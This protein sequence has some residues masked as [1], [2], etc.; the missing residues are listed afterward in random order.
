MKDELL[1]ALDFIDPSSLEYNDWLAVGIILKN[2][3]HSWT[4]WDSW[5]QKD[6]KRYKDGECENKWNGFNGSDKSLTKA[7][8]FKMAIEQ[9]YKPKR[10]DSKILNFDS[11]INEIHVEKKTPVEQL[12]TF[13]NI[14]FKDDDYVGYVTHEVK[15]DSKL[16]KYYPL[17]GI[18]T[19][20]KKELIDSLDYY[21]EDIHNTVGDTKYE[22]GGW[23]RINPLDGKGVKDS[24]VTRFDYCLVESDELSIDDQKDLYVRLQLPIA[25]LTLS[26]GKSV[27]AVIKIG[28]KNIEEYK[29]RVAYLYKYLDDNGLKVDKQNSNPSR[30]TRMPGLMRKENEQTLI[31]TNVGKPNWDEWY[32]LANNDFDSIIPLENPNLP[33]FPIEAFPG[34]VSAYCYEVAETTQTPVDMACVSALA[35]LALAMQRRYLV[36][37]KDDWKEQTSLYLMVVAEPSDRKSAVL[38][39]FNK[40]ISAFEIQYNK[41][42]EID[43]E[44][45]RIELKE[46]KEERNNVI[47][48]HKNKEATDDE[49]NDILK[50]VLEFKIMHKLVL[51]VDDVTPEILALRLFEQDESLAI[52]S[53]EGGLFDIMSGA[54]ARVV[55]IDVL[56]KGYSGDT[57]KVDRISRPPLCIVNPKLT[58][59]LTV[60]P[61]VL[62]KFV[63]NET[64]SGRGLNARFLYSVPTS[65]VGKRRFDTA[66]IEDINRIKFT[67]LIHDILS[68][69]KSEKETIYVTRKA[70]NVLRHY[71]EEF[72][73][74]LA[75]EYKEIGA[76]AGKL[77]GNILRI[78]AI[79]TR[80]RGI[81]YQVGSQTISDDPDAIYKVS[82][83]DM[84]NAIKIGEYF[85]THALYVFDKLGNSSRHKLAKKLVE[86]IK[87]RKP[88]LKTI[89]TREAMRMCKSL[90]DAE[91]TTSILNLLV[92]YGYLKLKEDE[93][94][95]SSK[96][97]RPRN[98]TYIVNPM[99]Y[100]TSEPNT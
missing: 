87:K 75:N 47:K 100:K 22:C 1:E 74:K 95:Y 27:H 18:F 30:L 23:I 64:F 49:L 32:N 15:Y 45:N 17:A 8:L 56:L 12:K 11:I 70:Q 10:P 73:K 19:R 2:E 71:Y 34:I 65:L 60:Q 89:T 50:K 9:G 61:K 81:R 98:T 91:T 93:G 42:H 94:G 69:D 3:G 46:L 92:D 82:E 59:L 29:S 90:K 62:E 39:Q 6:S 97:G 43:Y 54:Y 13:L 57:V 80:A 14:L 68:E 28:A 35:L 96:L 76:W 38:S 52:L 55:N 53:S 79:I 5:S 41:D 85:L 16:D 40:I 48:R 83:E 31:A 51:S 44:M 7:T 37:G 72:E 77:V 21:P 4:T 88:E 86:A 58:I 24:N 25:T 78:A 67:E 33:L 66:I 99:I 36:Q 26:G 84:N 20:T 63:N